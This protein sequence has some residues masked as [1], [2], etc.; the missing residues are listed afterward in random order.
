[1]KILNENTVIPISFALVIMSCTFW[2]SSISF[3]AEANA[4]EIKEIR[5][6]QQKY[7]ANIIEIRESLSRIEGIL[8]AKHGR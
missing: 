3:K 1:M 7:M 8:E 2:I 6:E 5:I 4:Q